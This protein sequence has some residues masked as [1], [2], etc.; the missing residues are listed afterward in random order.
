MGLEEIRRLNPKEKIM[1]I[2]EI[3]ESF[4]QDDTIESPR[5]HKEI[6]EQR[7]E[8]MKENKAKFI[9]LEELKNI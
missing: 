1:L 3:W 4:E 8:K 6:V 5:W 7:V 9:S 2:N